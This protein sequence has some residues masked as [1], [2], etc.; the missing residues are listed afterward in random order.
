MSKKCTKC[1]ETKPVESFHKR[2]DGKGGGRRSHCAVCIN[3]WHKQ[4]QINNRD[5]I[6]KRQAEYGKSEIGM[7]KKKLYRQ[8]EKGRVLRALSCKRHKENNPIKTKA[9]VATHHARR[10]GRL[11]RLACEVC[12]EPKTEAHHDD[13]SKPLEVRWLCRPHHIEHHNQLREVKQ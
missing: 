6:R 2:S 8:S 1:G 3:A 4:Y 10:A 11:I 12:G 5:K 9:R 13:Y 7:A